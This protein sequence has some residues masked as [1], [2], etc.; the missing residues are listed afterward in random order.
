MRRMYIGLVV[1]LLIGVLGVNVAFAQPRVTVASKNFTEQYIAAEIM[2]QLLEDQGFR[3]AR[4]V[5]LGS[6]PIIHRAIESGEIDLYAEYTGTGL[7]VHLNSDIISDP[8]EAYEVVKDAYKERY[9][10]V[11]L[12]PWGLNNTYA[13]AVR[14]D[15]AEEHGLETI[16][17]LEPIADQLT[18]GTDVEFEQRNDGYRN[19]RE[20]YFAFRRV[21]GMDVS[22]MY[23]AIDNQQVEV[24]TA[25][26]TDP[27]IMSLNL[28]ILEDDKDFFPPYHIAA[29][30][31]QDTLDQYPEIA[32][33]LSVL[34][35]RI[36]DDVMVDLNYQVD[37]E[38]RNYQQVVTSWLEEEGLI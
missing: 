22:L 38:G 9:D 34:D 17:D 13:I 27:R 6:S 29:V 11:W 14:E 2:A 25:F 30:V 1:V 3:V 4:Q 15:F 31:R 23:P 20:E 18:L 8:D 28:R 26:A 12:E 36:T 33:I 35:G 37:V 10:L 24:I 32:D 19:F 21:R 5:P 16:S 7:M